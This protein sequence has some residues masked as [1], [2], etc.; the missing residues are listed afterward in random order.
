VTEA[1]WFAPSV[2]EGMF[3]LPFALALISLLF[4]FTR[5]IFDESSLSGS[6]SI[7]MLRLSLNQF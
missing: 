4:V 7:S 5:V 1:D 2:R 3:L 6:W